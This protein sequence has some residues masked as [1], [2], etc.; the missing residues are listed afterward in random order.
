MDLD[1]VLQSTGPFGLFQGK[2][3]GICFFAAVFP[4]LAVL[5][6]VFVNY[7]PDHRCRIASCESDNSSY[8]EWFLDFTTPYDKSKNSWDQCNHFTETP[9]VSVLVHDY[10]ELYSATPEYST[11]C[12]QNY[13]SSSKTVD[14]QTGYVY[15]TDVFSSSTVMEY[16]LVC[17]KNSQLTVLNFS[18]MFGMFFGGILI[19]SIGDIFGRKMGMVISVLIVSTGGLGCACSLS[20]WML[21]VSRLLTGVG[22]NGL[23]QCAF[24][25]AVEYVVPAHRVA[26]GTLIN[27][28][29][30]LGGVILALMGYLVTDN[31]R[32]LVALS[33]MSSLVLLP[34]IWL[35]PE[36]LRWLTGK[37]KDKTALK[38]VQSMATLNNKPFPEHLMQK[39]AEIT[40]AQSKADLMSNTEPISVT[41]L[42]SA[43]SSAS[44]ADAQEETEKSVFDLL[45]KPNM[46]KRC[47]VSFFIWPSVTMAYY[48]LSANSATLG[49]NTFVNFGLS[50]IVEI[51]SYFL[52]WFVLDRI[53]RKGTV[54][55]MLLVSGVSCII[56]GFL[57]TDSSS[58]IVAFSLLGKFG[59]SAA[60][61][62]VYVFAS[63]VF[64]TEYRSVG[65]GSCSM[66]ARVGG[67][68]APIA[69]TLGTNYYKPI[70]LL[71]FGS[72]TLI[73]SGL[74]L[75]LP[76]TAKCELPDT[77]EE[78]EQFG[79]DQSPLFF[80]CLQGRRSGPS[81]PTNDQ[82]SNA[83]VQDVRDSADTTTH[84]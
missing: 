23:F 4:S 64:P 72:L 71:I 27:V 22:G 70:P 65:I 43:V 81:S 46:R 29:F 7:L 30:A 63:E 75:L 68:L 44:P 79:S 3:V 11:H 61:G 47:L 83:N 78:S 8:S 54:V 76:E 73:S 16:D 5:L 14:C 55:L 56:A 62:S 12:S 57:P 19:G 6:D 45:R 77:L 20:Y 48:G 51:P 10:E 25:L 36:S 74:T 59:A 13:F 66:C 82:N 17:D 34:L 80:M 28:L 33:T 26:V 9:N 1:T 21:L 38:V 49:G 58:L 84:S 60:F 2:V 67:I 24:I 35:L 50:S 53:G 42:S 39:Q 69:N 52:A 41:V 40:T 18:Y 37:G 31:W 32:T 15:E